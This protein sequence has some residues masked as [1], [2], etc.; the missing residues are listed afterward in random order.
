MNARGL[1][2][3][4]FGLLLA[5]GGVAAGEAVSG[6]YR[7]AYD[8]ADEPCLPYRLYAVDLTRTAPRHG[9][10]VVF[11]ASAVTDRFG[12]AASFTKKVAGLPGDRVRVTTM[13]AWVNGEF[14]GQLSP[15]VLDRAGLKAESLAR[16]WTLQDGEMFVVGTEAR[17]FDSRYYGPV[18]LTSVKGIAWALW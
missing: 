15:I 2:V 8:S 9:D 11:D 13:G 18:P 17:A 6:S 14:V 16:E 5:A 12:Q 10:L 4:A 3:A 7:L 1:R